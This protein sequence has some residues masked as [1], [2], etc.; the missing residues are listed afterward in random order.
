MVTI[1]PGLKEA[2]EEDDL[3]LFIGA[4]LSWGLKNIKKRIRGRMG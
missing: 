1:P 4:G 2:I 3:V